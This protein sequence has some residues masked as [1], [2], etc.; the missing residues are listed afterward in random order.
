MS[1]SAIHH[2]RFEYLKSAHWSDLRLKKLAETDARCAIC[3]I[4]DFSNDVHHLRYKRLFN[5]QTG[6]LVVL[7]RRCHKLTHEE[8]EEAALTI[9]GKTEEN[10]AWKQVKR[11]VEQEIA[12]EIYPAY[13]EERE[14]FKNHLIANGEF[15]SDEQLPPVT[16]GP[17]WFYSVKG[18]P[19]LEDWS[20][21]CRKLG[22]WPEKLLGTSI[23]CDYQI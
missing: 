14:K 9:F 11:R 7:C 3:K 5:V 2:Y 13:K 19:S 17:K 22:T 6:D 16:S 1:I 21:A 23:Y 18:L 15:I 8:I 20:R 4:Q 10:T 12:M